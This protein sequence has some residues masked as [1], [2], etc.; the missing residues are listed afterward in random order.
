MRTPKSKARADAASRKGS[1]FSAPKATAPKTMPASAPS[2]FPGG[3]LSPEEVALLAAQQQ[4]FHEE[5]LLAMAGLLPP[6][7]PGMPPGAAL[8]PGGIPA[9]YLDEYA[10]LLQQEQ[11]AQGAAARKQRPKKYRCPHC[12][13]AFSN[14]GQLR[15]H[16]RIHTGERPFQCDEE[17]CGKR[18]TRNEELTRHKRIH[19]GLRPFA[20]QACGKRFGRKDHLKK[21]TRTHDPA[22]RMAQLIPMLPPPHYLYGF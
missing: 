17:S 1:A 22:H 8:P 6:G 20:C 7:V 13:V 19:S 10:R 4:A 5:A 18:F 21:H 2:G 11:K 15:G 3:M 16:V 12:Q 14:N 9:A